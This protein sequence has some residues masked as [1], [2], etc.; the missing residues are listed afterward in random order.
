MFNEIGLAGYID[1]TEA[2]KNIIVPREGLLRGAHRVIDDL[3]RYY[4]TYH[5]RFL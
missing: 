3:L 5:Q 2:E 4:A 1:L